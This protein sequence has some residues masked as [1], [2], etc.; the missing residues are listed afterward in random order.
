MCEHT[1]ACTWVGVQA[2]GQ[3]CKSIRGQVCNVSV[4]VCECTRVGVAGSASR[5][6]R[7]RGAHPPASKFRGDTVQLLFLSG[8]WFLVHKTRNAL[9]CSS[10]RF[11][12]LPSRGLSSRERTWRGRLLIPKARILRLQISLW[13]EGTFLSQELMESRCVDRKILS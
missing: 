1:W 9:I 8:F 3:V 7:H 2:G 13:N 10:L 12:D 11:S 6:A 4:R 5:L